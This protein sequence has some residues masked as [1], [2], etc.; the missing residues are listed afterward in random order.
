MNSGCTLCV[1]LLLL[2]TYIVYLTT[3]GGRQADVRLPHRHFGG[4]V[5]FASWLHVVV[6]LAQFPGWGRHLLVFG[7]VAWASLEACLALLPLFIGAWLV[8]LKALC[9]EIE[10]AFPPQL[11]S[12]AVCLIPPIVKGLCH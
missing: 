4:Y 11:R 12:P 8:C 5:V 9:H 2:T 10:C 7:K 1:R 6:L 3:N